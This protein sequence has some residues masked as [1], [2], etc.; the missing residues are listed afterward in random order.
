MSFPPNHCRQAGRYATLLVLLCSLL[1]LRAQQ[2]P[3]FVQYWKLE[4]QL[5]PA[6]AGHSPQLNITGAFQAHATGFEDAG[7][8]MFAAADIALQLGKTRHG[9]GVAL[10]NDEIG[11]FSHKRFSLQYAYHFRLFGGLA[12]VGV[13]A[14]LLSE[15]V[16][17]S[18]ADLGD[19]NDPAFPASEATGS[20]L[21]MSAGICYTRG[22]FYAGFGVLHLLSPTVLLGETNELKIKNLFNFT[23]GYNIKTR[24]PFLTITPSALLR[25]DGSDLRADLT[26]RMTIQREKKRLYGGL[27]YSPGHGVAAFVGGTFHGVD[28]CYAYEA[29]TSGMGLASGNHEVTLGYILELDLGKRGKNKHKSVRWL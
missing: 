12:G 10:Q 20:K 23:T 16:D 21:D 3:A 15:G 9:V 17:G 19:A 28:L 7:S 13:E 27:N 26:A 8:T 29:N 22:R 25:Y 14:D 11:L 1:P 2:E 24:N 5:N 18:R 4:T 6:T